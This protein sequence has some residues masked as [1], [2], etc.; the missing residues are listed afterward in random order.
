MAA[1][2]LSFTK[3]SIANAVSRHTTPLMR[4]L[5]TADCAAVIFDQV[6]RHPNGTTTTFS[7]LALDAMGAEEAGGF[8]LAGM[9]GVHAPAMRLVSNHARPGQPPMDAL[10]ALLAIE[11]EDE[12]DLREAAWREDGE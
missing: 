2:H 7:V 6:W 1:G 12:R 3:R 11:E 5:T 8:R 4:P 10:Q 9:D